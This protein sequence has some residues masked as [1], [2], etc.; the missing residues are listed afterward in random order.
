MNTKGEIYLM[1]LLDNV[2]Q[3]RIEGRFNYQYLGYVI[4]G[5]QFLYMSR[6]ILFLNWN[7][8]IDNTM[9]FI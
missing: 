8:K 7:S 5:T 9:K 3:Y 2:D 1:I 6:Q 4:D